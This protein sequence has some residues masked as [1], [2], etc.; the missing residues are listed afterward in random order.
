MVIGVAI[1]ALLLPQSIFVVLFYYKVSD[2]L[3]AVT[4]CSVILAN[5]FVNRSKA[6]GCVARSFANDSFLHLRLLSK[7]IKRGHAADRYCE[8][9]NCLWIGLKT[10]K[11]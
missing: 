10:P 9:K 8:V 5:C 7:I 3:N 4:K 6:T 1:G 2:V 11:Q